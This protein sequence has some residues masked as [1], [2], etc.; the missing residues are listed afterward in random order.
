M[1]ETKYG[2]YFA[3]GSKP[4]EFR[5]S[6]LQEV[7]TCAY[8]ID[9]DR[10]KGAFFM[11]VHWI[12]PNDGFHFVHA[13]HYHAYT[14]NLV[15]MGTNPD[16]PNDFGGQLEIHLDHGFERHVITKPTIVYIPKQLVHG[17]ILWRIRKPVL[18]LGISMGPIAEHSRDNELINFKQS[19]EINHAEKI[20]QGPKPGETRKFFK[21][22]VVYTDDDRVKGSTF[23][24]TKFIKNGADLEEAFSKTVTSPYDTI[25]GF[26]GINPAEKETLN[27]EIQI[28]MGKEGEK[29]TFN[30]TTGVFIPHD[31]V[32]GPI[33]CK[34]NKPFILAVATNGPRMEEIPYKG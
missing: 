11:Y 4:G 34:L 33:K 7:D 13:P 18:G 31:F 32:R 2:K 28:A 12:G 1:T 15:S 10:M 9:D 26:I 22:A 25:L 17:P 3:S 27:A 29:H 21:D 24:Y 5:W 19:L 6:Y 8:K 30:K 14:D 20:I 23:I 16:D